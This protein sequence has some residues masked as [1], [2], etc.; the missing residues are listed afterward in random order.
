MVDL[1]LVVKNG[2]G[3]KTGLKKPVYGKHGRNCFFFGAN[4][5]FFLVLAL[6]RDYSLCWDRWEVVQ[7]PHTSQALPEGS[8]VAGDHGSNSI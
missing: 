1:C 2:A 5:Y 8:W 3:L 7:T 4:I 6:L